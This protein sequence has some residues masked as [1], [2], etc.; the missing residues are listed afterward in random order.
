MDVPSP[1]PGG[2]GDVDG[3]GIKLDTVLTHKGY[4]VWY[5]IHMT[6]QATANRN[7]AHYWDTIIDNELSTDE[8]AVIDSVMIT[9]L[10]Y[11]VPHRH[12][13]RAVAAAMNVVA[14]G[15]AGQARQNAG[16]QLALE[17]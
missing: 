5:A 13:A 10:M 4:Q 2:R 15:R 16:D 17:V 8:Q 7:I 11:T 12:F 14:I 3:K 6:Q 9:A 1:S